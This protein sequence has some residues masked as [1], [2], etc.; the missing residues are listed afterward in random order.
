M[1]N[2][3]FLPQLRKRPGWR[4]YFIAILKFHRRGKH[5]SPAKA[6]QC[7]KAPRVEQSPTPTIYHERT[8]LN[9]SAISQFH[10][11]GG[12]WLRPAL[13]QLRT[14][15][16]SPAPLA[17]QAHI[18]GEHKCD[19][20]CN[21]GDQTCDSPEALLIAGVVDALVAVLI[22]FGVLLFAQI[23]KQKQQR[24]QHSE[25]R[26]NQVDQCPCTCGRGAKGVCSGS[27]TSGSGLGCWVS[28]GFAVGSEPVSMPVV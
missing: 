20:C 16:I 24:C 9:F 25:Q 15:K 18:F 7:R 5:C 11:R 4:K 22:P 3:F 26:Q 2:H 27:I 21:S 13:P 28:V 14:P 8:R 6:L 23:A 17:G 1:Q 12:A 19:R 10:R